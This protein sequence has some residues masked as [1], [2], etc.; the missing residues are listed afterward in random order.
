[1][2]LITFYNTSIIN[3]YQ[4]EGKEFFNILYF[5]FNPHFLQTT[6]PP[7]AKTR[8]PRTIYVYAPILALLLRFTLHFESKFSSSLP[9]E[10]GSCSIQVP[11]PIIRS[12]Y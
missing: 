7:T 6:N 11:E 3:I 12:F 5:F 1:M 10:G 8:F 2:N 4:K 9:W